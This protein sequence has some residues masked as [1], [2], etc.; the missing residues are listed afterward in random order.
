MQR[1]S[2]LIYI[3]VLSLESSSQ[4]QKSRFFMLLSIIPLCKMLPTNS[5]T[6]FVEM[7][8]AMRFYMLPVQKGQIQNEQSIQLKVRIEGIR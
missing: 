3:S 5:K 6:S 8:C 7:I 1:N 2:P 4:N